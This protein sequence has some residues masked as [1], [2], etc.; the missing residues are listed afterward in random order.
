M[1]LVECQNDLAKATASV[2]PAATALSLP[3]AP[4]NVPFTYTDF[5]SV[6]PMKPSTSS[7]YLLWRS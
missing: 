7:R 4:F 3:S 2:V 1:P 6:N 5:T